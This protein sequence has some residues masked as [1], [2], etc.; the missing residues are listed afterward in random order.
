MEADG[1]KVQ[2]GAGSRIWQ[3][4]HTPLCQRDDLWATNDE[5]SHPTVLAEREA[6]ACKRGAGPRASRGPGLLPRFLCV[7]FIPGRALSGWWPPT[8][9][10]FTLL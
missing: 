1:Q 9:S 7:V 10:G 8:V 6:G 4:Q 5:N 3:V 2:T